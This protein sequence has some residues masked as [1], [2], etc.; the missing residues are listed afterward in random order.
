MQHS[1]R[2]R[3]LERELL[4]YLIFIKKITKLTWKPI[5]TLFYY[6]K[7][8]IILVLILPCFRGCSSLKLTK[9]FIP[10]FFFFDILIYTIL[11]FLISFEK[12]KN[13]EFL[14]FCYS[15]IVFP[16]HR[17]LLLYSLELF[18][19]YCWRWQWRRWRKLDFF[20][21]VLNAAG[22]TRKP[23]IAKLWW[24]CDFPNRLRL[25]WRRRCCALSLNRSYLDLTKG[26]EI[27]T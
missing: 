14:G 2:W 3:R 19:E 1:L 6:L 23:E 5:W 25:L 9:F 27:F 15:L 13:R 18:L 24:L 26:S 21:A 16:S 20:S 22:F 8:F 11:T 17:R 12:V 7:L 4:V 10:A